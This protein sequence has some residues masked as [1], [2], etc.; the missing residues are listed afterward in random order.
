MWLHTFCAPVLPLV[1]LSGLIRPFAP[2]LP[3]RSCVKYLHDDTKQPGA[4]HFKRELKFSPALEALVRKPQDRYVDTQTASERPGPERDQIQEPSVAARNSKGKRAQPPALGELTRKAQDTH[5]N[6][7]NQDASEKSG[8]EKDQI[9]KHTVATREPKILSERKPNQAQT[10]KAYHEKARSEGYRSL[11]EYNHA[12]LVRDI[13]AA[14]RRKLAEDPTYEPL[15]LPDMECRSPTVKRRK[16][17][18]RCP[19][20]ACHS[21]RFLDERT[22]EDHPRRCHGAPREKTL[23]KCKH[24]DCDKHFNTKGGASNHFSRSHGPFLICPICE[25][26]YV[27]ND[28]LRHHLVHIHG[29]ERNEANDHIPPKRSGPSPV[30]ETS[31]VDKNTL[32]IQH[33]LEGLLVR[34]FIRDKTA[35]KCSICDKALSDK[36]TFQLHL[37][38]IHGMDK[39]EIKH[40]TSRH[41]PGPKCAMC[42]N[43]FSDQ[44]CLTSHLV[45]VHGIEKSLA[46]L[47][48]REET[49]IK[50]PVCPKTYKSKRYLRVH[51]TNI[52]RMERKQVMHLTGRQGSG[53]MTCSECK[54]RFSSKQ[55]LKNH[56]VARHGMVG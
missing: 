6:V 41:G 53:P 35:H 29:I 28:R 20:P 19:D 26:S 10:M 39:E 23:Y 25:K 18:I 17:S 34:S 13:E 40:H 54:R 56:L 14:N 2:K 49:R 37:T 43:S 33:G 44:E 38:H 12:T 52:H 3:P 22:L 42:E 51:M 47:Y 9:E 16:A 21:K 32:D 15:P 11:A 36:L 24:P 45:N 4:A 55:A 5:L 46:G 1:T 48:T 27:D 8:L 31:L 50:C 7:Q 30:C